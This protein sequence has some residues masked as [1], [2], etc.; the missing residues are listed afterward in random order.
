MFSTEAFK[1]L[2]SLNGKQPK[3]NSSAKRMFLILVT[4]LQEVIWFRSGFN[5]RLFT[6][7]LKPRMNE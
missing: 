5:L 1:F 7:I 2:P 4:P 3:N 6:R